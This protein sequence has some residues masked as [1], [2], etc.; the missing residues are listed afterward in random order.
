VSHNSP[1]H[2]EP[3]IPMGCAAEQRPR[4]KCGAE[5]APGW[6]ECVS[7]EADFCIANPA[8][9]DDNYDRGF[10]DSAAGREVVAIVTAERLRRLRAGVRVYGRCA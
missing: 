10:Y 5:P 3:P 9:Y 6:E 7:C 1:L 4:C 2:L 8:E